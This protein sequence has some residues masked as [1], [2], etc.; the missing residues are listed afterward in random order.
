[1]WFKKKKLPV[2]MAKK[3][4]YHFEATGLEA[5]L[6]Y[7]L[8]ECGVDLFGKKEVLRMRIQL[9]CENREIQSY[10]A[11]LEQVH[12]NAVLRQE[13]LNLLTVNET[14][15][16]REHRQL[17]HAVAFA[18]SLKREVKVLCA[19]CA[20]GEEVYSLAL[21]FAEEGLTE[22]SITGI[23]INSDAIASA[24][25]GV[26]SKRAVHKIDAARLQRYFRPEREAFSIR[27]DRLCPIALHVMNIFHRELDM[28]GHFDIIFCRNMLIY[29]D[30]PHRAE[31]A[32]QLRGRLN[33]GG[34][35]YVGHADFLPQEASL[36]K[37]YS[38]EIS[39]YSGEHV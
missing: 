31:A 33:L 2:E 13:L 24:R 30:D 25:R 38:G 21:L 5:L 3:P 7:I 37:R 20:S 29:F 39:Y 32:R 6:A 14:F 1:M 28:L 35:L 23:D 26:Y 12:I 18:R 16:L 34:R 19:P 15:F 22:V 9:F 8:H 4:L 11:L 17:E 10:T 27:S 36:H